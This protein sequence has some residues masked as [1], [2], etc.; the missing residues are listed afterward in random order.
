MADRSF[1]RRRFLTLASGAVAMTA[2]A[3]QQAPQASPPPAVTV[4][5]KIITATP[6]SQQ[7]SQ[8]QTI[9][10]VVTA[11]PLPQIAGNIDVWTF[12]M[13][14]DDQNNL[15]KALMEKFKKDSPRINAKV[16]ILPWSGRREKMMTA[17]AA[18][19]PPDVAYVNTDTLSL[20]GS[21]DALH[22]L[23]S[24][25]PADVWADYPK[26]VTGTGLEWKGKR[27]MIPTLL[28]VTGRIANQE[29]LTAAGQDPQKPPFVWSDLLKLGAP[30]KEKGYFLTSWSLVNWDEWINTI[31]QAGGTVLNE[32]ATKVLLDQAP[33]EDALTFIVELFQKGYVPKEG[34][35]S[36]E[37]ESAAASA[38]DYFMTG[39]QVLSGP[40]N[41]G[42]IDQVKQQA[43][44]LKY[45]ILPPFK[46]KEQVSETSSGC[47]G[48]FNRGK[49]I[50]ASARWVNFMVAP[51]NQGFYCSVT[52]FIPPRQAAN[53]YWVVADELKQ[54]ANIQLPMTRIN[55]DMNYFFQEGKTTMAPHFQ[56]AVLG[57][58]TVKQA[59]AD[60]TRELQKIVDDF[61][62]KQK[63]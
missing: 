20:F 12:P 39:K 1:S 42:I 5:E 61:W 22:E 53:A 8:P 13:T 47:W 52:G 46:N 18:G 19:T 32:D 11:T 54:F 56:A 31:W 50:E 28:E 3:C 27:I 57:K 21:N 55:Q 10:K 25:V 43:P 24:L 29:L 14:K 59:L 6:S 40:E 23:D 4:V 2:L 58:A 45:V 44:K 36:S 48:I 38:V 63:K 35:V 62:A 33:A 9:E 16:E 7:A 60:G 15:W 17:F 41:P 37:Q 49:N 34:A 51:E 26:G 30:A